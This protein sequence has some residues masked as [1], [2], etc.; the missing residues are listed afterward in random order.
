MGFVLLFWALVVLLASVLVSAFYG[1]GAS[2][3]V[4]GFAYLGYDTGLQLALLVI[5]WRAVEKTVPE[6]MGQAPTLAVLVPC[7]NEATVL[8]ACIAALRSQLAAGDRLLVI[9]DGS[10]D[11]TA[12]WCR[13]TGIEVLVKANSGKAASLNQGIQ[14][15]SQPL[16]VTIDADTVVR[17][18]A[19]A[20]VRDAFRDPTLVAAGG[21]LEIAVRPAPFAGWL[22]WQQRAEY[23]RSFLWRASWEHW[24]TLLLISGAFAVYR[25]DAVLAVGGLSTSSLTEDYDLTHRLHRWAIDHRLDWRLGMIPGAQAVTDAPGTVRLFLAQRMRWFSGFIGVHLANRDLVFARR[26]GL[27][28]LVMLPIKTIDLLLPLYGLFAIAVLVAFLLFGF[29]VA[30]VIIWAL[31]IKLVL[32]LLTAA[33]AIR[34][35][36]RWAGRAPGMFGVLAATACEPF[37][38]QGLRQFAALLGWISFLRRRTTWTPQR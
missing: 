36:R 24:G 11:G 9:D 26:A 35:T 38:Y 2:A 6:V 33:V 1:Q 23:L 12:D 25:R 4:I 30:P 13:A 22:A 5:A 21:L 18:G 31:A 27:L 7:R 17:P 10:I 14:A 8:P 32:D 34:L 19:L 3:W 28:G 20:A 15:V 37:L 29:A 16:V